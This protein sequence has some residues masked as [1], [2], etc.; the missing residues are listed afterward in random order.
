MKQQLGVWRLRDSVS[1]PARGRGLKRPKPEKLEVT[2]LVAPRTGAW[3][4]TPH[5]Y[6]ILRGNL[7]APRT[8]AW[9][10]T[11]SSTCDL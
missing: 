8:G 9:I 4:E 11:M 5:L 1:P 2:F 6:H 10:E 7:V 3:I